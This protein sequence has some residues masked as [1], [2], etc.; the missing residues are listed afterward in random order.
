MNEEIAHEN[1]IRFTE[2]GLVYLLVQDN[3]LSVHD[4][5]DVYQ[6]VDETTYLRPV[7]LFTQDSNAENMG[8][9]TKDNHG[10]S[11]IVDALDTNLYYYE[12]TG[13]Y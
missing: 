8:S 3:K 2:C 12:S 10:I 4:Q 5:Q 1:G 7:W 6:K 13:A 9:L 11:V